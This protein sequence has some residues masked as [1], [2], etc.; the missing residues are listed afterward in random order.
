MPA[1]NLRNGQGVKLG[2]EN[3]SDTCDKLLFVCIQLELP[4][5]VTVLAA[6]GRV[7]GGT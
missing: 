7:M 6:M 5:T 3:A 2:E 1:G 4:V